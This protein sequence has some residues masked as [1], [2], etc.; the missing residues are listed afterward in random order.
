MKKYECVFIFNESKL[1]NGAEAFIATATEFIE[2][3]GGKVIESED[4]GRKTFSYPIKRKNSG[5]YWDLIVELDGTNVASL[6]EHYRLDE[7]VLRME[8]LN[9]DRPEK[10]VTLSTRR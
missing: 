8:V 9:F 6:K 1:E 3:I 2:S 4:M 10:P 7:A 5:L